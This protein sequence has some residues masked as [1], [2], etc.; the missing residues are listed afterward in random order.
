[1]T[2]DHGLATSRIANLEPLGQTPLYDS[3]EQALGLLAGGHYPS[4]ALLVITDGMDNSS[5]TDKQDLLNDIRNRGWPL[6]IVGIGDPNES[7]SQILPLTIGPF[8]FGADVDRVDSRVL[9]EM[10]SASGGHA[11]IVAE[12]SK[13]GGRA[14]SEAISTIGGV[15]GSGYVL[16]AALPKDSWQPMAPLSVSVPSRPDA[17][18]H[19]QRLRP[20]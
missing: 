9:N 16:V 5:K 17:T 13:D 7:Q 20:P 11:F 18:I 8:V 15:I 12:M 6:F 19:I 2:T 4:R 3:I 10:A 1:L 14:F